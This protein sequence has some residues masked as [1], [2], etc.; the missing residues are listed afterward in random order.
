MTTGNSC[1]SLLRKTKTGRNGFDAFALELGKKK[2]PMS[3]F[4]IYNALERIKN[5]GDIFKPVLGIGITLEKVIK[6]Y[7]KE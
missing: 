1:S 4:T 6:I 3:E 2:L 7:D 5:E